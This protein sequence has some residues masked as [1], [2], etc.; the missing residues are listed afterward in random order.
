MRSAIC[1][2]SVIIHGH[3]TSVSL[4][5]QFWHSFKEIAAR[6]GLSASALIA[7]IDRSRDIGNLSSAVRLFVLQDLQARVDRNV[8]F[9]A[10]A[11]SQF[12]DHSA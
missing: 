8:R 4:E 1:K 2:R 12:S 6:E 10:T 11:Q 3:K 9:A 7:Q 5:T